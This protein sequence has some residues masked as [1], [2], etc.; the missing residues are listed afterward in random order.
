MELPEKIYHLISDEKYLTDEVGMSEASVLMFKDKVLKIQ[1][2]SEE[3]ENEYHMMT[4]LR[5]KLPLPE[6][7]AYEVMD[8][9]SY[10]L[11]S[12]CKG[13]MSCADEYMQ[14]SAVQTRLLAEGLKKLW[15]VDV[16]GCPGN[17]ELQR[18]LL[19][20]KYN[21]ENH[22]VDLD[23]VEPSTFGEKGFKDPTELLQWLYENQPAQ[24]LV[25]SHGD[26]CLPNVFFEGNEI[27]GYID[28]GKTG[29]ADKWCDIALC[30]RSLSHNYSGK[31]N[32]TVYSGYDDMLLFQELGIEPEWE[33][34]RYY[35]LLD[36][37]F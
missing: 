13:K 12:R 19:Q 20:A 34:I 17:W 9:N 29:V 30:Y 36:E 31:Y 22:L 32:K 11:M 4:W 5:G 8:G 1:K 6:V 10:L 2:C 26:Y 24:E 7:Y 21:V 16:S 25:L 33:K 35:I 14:N 23:N 37:L 18:K 15:S 27:S 28:L 3:A